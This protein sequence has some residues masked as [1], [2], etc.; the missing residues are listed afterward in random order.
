MVPFREQHEPGFW[1][2]LVEEWLQGW[3]EAAAQWGLFPRVPG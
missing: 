2:L 3:P 1:V